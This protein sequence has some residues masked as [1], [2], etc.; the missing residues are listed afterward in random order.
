MRILIA[1]TLSFLF[2]ILAPNIGHTQEGYLRVGGGYGIP[3]SKDVFTLHVLELDSNNR[4]ISDKNIYGTLG[5]GAQFRIAGGYTFAQNFG[6]ELDVNYFIGRKEY[7]G[8]RVTPIKTD[9][10]YAYSRQLRISPS[11]FVRANPGLIQPYVG[12]GIV[13]PVLG[14]TVV[15]ELSTTAQMSS[16]RE[17]HIYGSFSVGFESYA[18]V[19]IS[20]PNNKFNLFVECRYSGLRIKSKNA[21]MLQWTDTDLISGDVVNQLETAQAFL[22]EIV[23][24]DELTTESNTISA[25]VYSS[26]FD[27]DK[28]LEV[29][30]S[31]SN[32]N[33]ISLS[34][35]V[36]IKFGP[37]K[38]LTKEI[39][40]D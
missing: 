12:M 36:C 34:I 10:T 1:T 35:G 14:K 38:E 28:P 17:R 9:L 27:F 20:W 25:T 37:D 23:F 6:L 30:A 13:L 8:E 18:G 19:N 22:K 2:F 3:A 15:E 32:Y 33:A 31:K 4:Y 39:I 40:L 29:L 21:E 11:F 16:Y 24:K 26:N 7:A 5:A